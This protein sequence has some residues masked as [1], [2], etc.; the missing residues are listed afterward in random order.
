MVLPLLAALARDADVIDRVV[1][2]H[3]L[4]A[5]AMPIP[6][7]PWP[8][9]LAEIFNASPRG[10]AANHNAALLHCDSEF[11]CVLNPDIEL[12][13]PAIWQRLLQTVRQPGVGCAY[14]MLMNADGSR[15]ENER[16][17]VSPLALLRRHLL[18]RPQRTVDWASGAFWLVAAAAWRELGGL[19][20][21]Y[22]M[23]CEDTDF[24]L[25][26]Q[27]AGW[28][29]ERADAVALHDANWGSRKDREHLL[30][31]V[32][33]LLRLWCQPVLWRYLHSQMRAP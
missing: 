5:D 20:E 7:Q 3:N 11:F 10:F 31:H 33:S 15:Q 24:C 25:R 12:C 9:Q 2:T 6:A 19:D 32:R 18:K 17:A 16:E 14:P 28:R 30:W 4:P 13:D 29:L 22:Y 21:R 26:L 27:L 23:Y 1:V 8:F